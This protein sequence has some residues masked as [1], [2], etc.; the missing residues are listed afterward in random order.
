ML[1]L[2]PLIEDLLHPDVDGLRHFLRE[3]GEELSEGRGAMRPLCTV[4]SFVHGKTTDAA[5][6]LSALDGLDRSRAATARRRVVGQGYV[7]R[8]V[9]LQ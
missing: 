9:C 6:A 4:F 5:A 3:S 2:A 7:R 8:G 1:R